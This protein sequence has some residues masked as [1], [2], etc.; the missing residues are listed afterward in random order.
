MNVDRAVENAVYG[1]LGGDAGI[2]VAGRARQLAV[3]VLSVGMGA[4][5][6]LLVRGVSFVA[7]VSLN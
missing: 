2:D 1:L 5:G 4:V 7:N 6:V 3:S